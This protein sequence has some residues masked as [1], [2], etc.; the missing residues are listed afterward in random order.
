[1]AWTAPR[2][3]VTNETVTASHMNTHVR[4]NMLETAPAKA[5]TSGGFIVTVGVNEVIQ[6]TPIPAQVATSQ[7]TTSTSYT[8]LTTAGPAVT[9]VTGTRALVSISALIQNNTAGG[10]TWMAVT[11]SGASA[12]SAADGLGLSL[13]S[14]TGGG[15]ASIGRTI[16]YSGLT[17]GTNT[18][19]AKYR[20][21]TGTGTFANRRIEVVPF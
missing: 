19:T 21:S 13:Q 8:D 17:Q 10:E 15:K 16:I 3:W 11:V 18:F 7:T 6:R 14:Y 12:V 4:D 20:V 5:T 2:T 1:M 9:E